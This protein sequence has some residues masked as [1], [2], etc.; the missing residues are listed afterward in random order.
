MGIGSTLATIGVGFATGGLPGAAAAGGKL[1]ADRVNKGGGGPAAAA[2][3]V[4]IAATENALKQ[5]AKDGVRD[6]LEAALFD[7]EIAKAN[8][9]FNSAEKAFG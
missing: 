9:A 8:L 1:L 6:K 5:T 3:E 2:S 4:D 7:R